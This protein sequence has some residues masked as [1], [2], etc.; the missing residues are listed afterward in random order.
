MRLQ[1]AKLPRKCAIKHWHACGADG[2]KV[3]RSVYGAQDTEL[4]RHSNKISAE[5]LKKYVTPI[6]R[7]M[8]PRYSQVCAGQQML[9]SRAQFCILSGALLNVIED[10]CYFLGCKK[11][12]FQLD[13]R[14]GS[15]SKIAL[16][17]FTSKVT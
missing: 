10:D 8:S 11:G 14:F 6:G 15:L 4:S 7:K 16:I 9:S 2:R 17:A 1:A 3:G 5:N 12:G 13:V